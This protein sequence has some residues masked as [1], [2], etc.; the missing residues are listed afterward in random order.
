MDGIGRIYKSY[1]F[2][3]VAVMSLLSDR[4]RIINELKITNRLT[5]NE[6]YH[7]YPNIQ[8]PKRTL[9][10][11]PFMSGE[12]SYLSFLD[13]TISTEGVWLVF[14]ITMFYRYHP[15]FFLQCKQCRP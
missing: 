7:A 11:T 10:L 2:S 9:K 5:V 12:L 1:K 15:V 3:N 4:G 14:I 8:K 6:Q 13:R